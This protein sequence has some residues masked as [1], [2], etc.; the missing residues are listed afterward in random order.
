MGTQ[1]MS[2]YG[3]VSKTRTIT[4]RPEKLTSV[5][6][7]VNPLGLSFTFMCWNGFFCLFIWG[8]DFW[9]LVTQVQNPETIQFPSSSFLK[10]VLFSDIFTTCRLDSVGIE[11][12]NRSV[13]TCETQSLFLTC[14]QS[15]GIK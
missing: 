6:R 7:F 5:L 2:F 10:F 15:L 1:T 12:G 3:M 13:S 8:L 14:R 4:P 9:H 11:A